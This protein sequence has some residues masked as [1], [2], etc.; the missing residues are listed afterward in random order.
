MKQCISL[1]IFLTL[2]FYYWWMYQIYKWNQ[3]TEKSC[4]VEEGVPSQMVGEGILWMEMWG[5]WAVW[6]SPSSGLL[7]TFSPKEK[8]KN[9]RIAS[10]QND[11][12]YKWNQ[13]TENPR[14]LW[15]RGNRRRR[16]VREL[17]ELNNWGIFRAFSRP[18]SGLQ[19]PFFQRRK[20]LYGL[21]VSS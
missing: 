15:E 12:I 13:C 19:L 20:K 8:A 2:W 4:P 5:N 16:W 10:S 3:F 14:P 21:F 6:S 18:S 1:I 17:W 9:Q 7:A 11:Q